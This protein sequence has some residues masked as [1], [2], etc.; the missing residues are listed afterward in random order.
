[1]DVDDGSSHVRRIS[2]AAVDRRY[3]FRMTQPPLGLR[4]VVYK[5]GDLARA[6]AWYAD[7]F[8]RTP[9]FDEPFYVGFDVGGYEL[10]LDPDHEGT[11]PGPGG[12]TAY[13]G[14][15]NL[16]A[17]LASLETRGVAL[18]APP[19]DVGDGIRVATVQDPFG[20]VVGF[21]ENP[22]FTLGDAAR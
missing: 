1:M 15:A 13:W 17:F 3:T 9:Y 14:V 20:N 4:T 10:G 2:P 6:R 12:A 11:P 16:A 18:H 5:V 22:H 7:V 8:Q 19:R 21:I